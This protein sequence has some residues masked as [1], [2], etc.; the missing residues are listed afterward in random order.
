MMLNC[1]SYFVVHILYESKPTFFLYID[2]QYDQTEEHIY[3]IKE[4]SVGTKWILLSIPF[5]PLLPL[6]CVVSDLL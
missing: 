6:Y 3:N 2:I 5:I 4:W 1:I